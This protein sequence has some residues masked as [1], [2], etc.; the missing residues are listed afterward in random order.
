MICGLKL[1]VGCCSISG[2]MLLKGR[3]GSVSFGRQRNC[4][5]PGEY[6]GICTPE[7][8]PLRAARKAVPNITATEWI[9]GEKRRGNQQSGSQPERWT[10][11]EHCIDRL[12][13]MIKKIH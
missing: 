11:V 4:G 13:Q 2:I 9:D 3:G 12:K 1:P 8:L 10:D 6:R 5:D 7:C